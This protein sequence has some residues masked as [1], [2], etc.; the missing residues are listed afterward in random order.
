MNTLFANDLRVARRNSGLSQTD[1]AI[2]L[3][4]SEKDVSAVESGKRLPTLLQITKLS[5]VFNKVFPSLYANVRQTAR[6]ELFQ[7][8]PSLPAE[9]KKGAKDTF[10][11][12]NTLKRL[13]QRLIDILM[14]SGDGTA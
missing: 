10:N 5:L 1:V 13:E 11:R 7:Q 14:K 8:I 3:D 2:L 12:E 9:G 4:T 6:Q